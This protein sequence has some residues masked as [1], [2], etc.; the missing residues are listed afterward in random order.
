[1]PFPVAD[2]M[3][4]TLCVLSNPQDG[5]WIEVLRAPAWNQWAQIWSRGDLLGKPQIML[6]V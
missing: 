5:P 4:R 6:Y 1:M 3:L 2:N